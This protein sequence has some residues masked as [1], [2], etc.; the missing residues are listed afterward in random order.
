MANRSH[1]TLVR[2][3]FGARTDAYV[4]SP[5]HATG[6]DLDQLA[7]AVGAR[8]A[9]RV[10][11]L[12]CGGGHVAFRLAPLV[13]RVAALDMSAH[14]LEAV[15]AEAARRGLGNIATE[16]G[17][18]ESLPFADRSFD[19]VA[20]RYSAHHW[21]DLPACLREA[22]RVLK[23]GGLAV[24]MDTVAP[25]EALADTHLQAVELLRDPS[26]V[27]DYSVAQWVRA[28]EEAGFTPGEPV[29]RRVRLE[30]SSWIERM[31]TPEVNVR[32]IRSLLA[33]APGEVARHFG[34][35]ADGSFTVDAM[36]LE[37]ARP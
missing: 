1:E 6:E 8:P 22:R 21:R 9:A 7:Q 33:G 36:T 11:D 14:M 13:G 12:G 34:I 4:A 29:L 16:H 25:G 37:A 28:L 27:R 35:E 10:L 3:Q 2:A 30:F 15:A 17:T 32:A 23:P 18:A 19:V 26:H 20:S 24:F 5:V 31:R